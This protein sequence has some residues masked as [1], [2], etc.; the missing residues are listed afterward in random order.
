MGIPIEDRK[1]IFDWTNIMIGADDPDLTPTEQEGQ[2]AAANMYMYA[3]K[4]AEL[5]RQQPKTNIVGALIDG[6]VEGEYLTDSEFQSFFMLLVVAGNETTRTVTSHGMRLLI[7]YPEQHQKL[8]DHPELVPDFIEEVLRFHTAVIQFTRTATE[9]VELGGQLIKAGQRVSMFYH[10][11]NRDE[12]IFENPNS[13]DI[14]RPQ[15]EDVKGL[16]RAFGFGEHFCLGTHLARLELR[17]IFEEIIPR[18]QNP[19]HTGETVWLRSMLI[20]GIKRMPIEFNAET[21]LTAS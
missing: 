19:S 21:S 16:H 10:S 1:Q 3:A 18:L 11:A 6:V 14:T 7:E 4:L 5:H 2:M 13:F 17:V 15:R 20:N 12:A 9:D 8:I